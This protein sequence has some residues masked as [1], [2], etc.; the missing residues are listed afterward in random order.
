MVSLV[1]D[2]VVDAEVVGVVMTGRV[3]IATAMVGVLGGGVD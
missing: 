1:V 2:A 3:G